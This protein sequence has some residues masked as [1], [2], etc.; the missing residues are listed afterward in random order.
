MKKPNVN[1]L[2]DYLFAALMKAFC[3]Q[4]MQCFL[5]VCAQINFPV[6]LEKTHWGSTVLTFLGLLLDTEKQLICI[7]I[8]KL[9]KAV[10]WVN[11][12]LNK[13]N[14]KATVL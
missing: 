8:D 5:D 14:K 11:Y 9:M 1:Y 4:Q 10:D 6:A 13:K 3:D 7:P 2:D 12:F